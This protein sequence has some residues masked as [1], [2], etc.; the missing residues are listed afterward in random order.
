MHHLNEIMKG[1]LTEEDKNL[2]NSLINLAE[3]ERIDLRNVNKKNKSEPLNL[4]FDVINWRKSKFRKSIKDFKMPLK[5]I[6]FL[7]NE[8]SALVINSFKKKFDSAEDKDFYY[9]A[10]KNIQPKSNL[11]HILTY[12]DKKIPNRELSI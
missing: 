9:A 12:E 3:H 7:T 5:S 1:N 2:A 11:L 8:T 6:N 10:V 4:S